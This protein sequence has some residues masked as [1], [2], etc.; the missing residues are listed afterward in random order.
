MV[1]ICPR[2]KSRLWNVPR[3]L[4]RPVRPAG[5]GVREVIDPHRAAI[6]RLC[7]RYAVA[8][9]RVF[10]S[11]ARGEAGPSS[12]VDILV[13]YSRPVSLLTVVEL[14]MA[15]EKLLRRRVDLSREEMLHWAVRPQARADAVEL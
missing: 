8:R 11:V 9:L 3:I 2:C 15:L 12:D 13:E 4:P 10:G 6:R 5:L 14:R 1:H 7:R